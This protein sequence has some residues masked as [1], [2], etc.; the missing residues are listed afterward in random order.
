MPQAP[1]PPQP[2]TVA[3]SSPLA[4]PQ[5]PIASL[6]AALRGH[7][8][9][10]RELGQGAYATV[11]LARDL[12]HERKVAIKVLHA[13][14]NSEMGELR[15][16]REIRM[17]ARLQHPNILPLHDSGHVETLLY[18]VMPYV[19]GETLRDRIDRERRLS[20]DAAC[21]IAREVADALAYAHAQGIIHR[22]IKP[23]NILLSAGHP[24]LADFGIARVIDIAGVRQLTRTGMGSPG[25]PAYM[26][27]EQLLGDNA[28]DA[29]SDTYSLG[30]VLYEMLAGKPPF[31]G[32]EGFVKRF[33]GPPP[34]IAQARPDAA[35]EVS[36]ILKKCLAREPDD[37]FQTAQDF[38]SALATT[39]KAVNG[40]QVRDER[41]EAADRPN[42]NSGTLTYGDSESRPV[43]HSNRIDGIL[44]WVRTH[45]RGV[46]ISLAAVALVAIAVA[47]TQ[48]DSV[49]SVFSP[50]L[51]STQIAVLPIA[52]AA[53]TADRA[54]LTSSLF[55]ALS[56]WRGLRLLGDDDVSRQLQKR[57]VPNSERAAAA[58]ARSLGAG[59]FIWGEAGEGNGAA[60]RLD[61]VESAS[62]QTLRTVSI[63]VAADS[64]AMR[65]VVIQ[66]LRSPTRPGSADGGDGRTTSYPAWTAYGR[67]HEALSRVELAD[68]EHRF[69]E[70]VAADPGFAPA[71]FW[72]AQ[73]LFWRAPGERS[74]W[75][76]HLNQ[77]MSGSAAL[78]VRDRALAVALSNLGDR[79][80][81]EA[82]A[83]YSALARDSL[84]VVAQYGL[85]Q[86]LS[87][88][89]VVVPS[90]SSPSGWSFRSRY[91]DAAHAF[92]SALSANPNAHAILAFDQL[93]ELLPIAPTKTRRGHSID[94]AEFAAYPSLVHDTV[95]F[96]PY[97]V[98]EF[99][100]LPAERT[101]PS[102][103][104]A[105]QADLEFL[106]DFTLD[107]TRRA[108]QSAQAFL[109]L[110][111]VRE[112]RGEISRSRYGE[113][114]A[115]DAARHA[116]S[117]S[118][119]AREQLVART[120]EAW[121]T[122]K[123]GEFTRARVLA[124][125]LLSGPYT[126]ADARDLIGL[127]ALTGKINKT[128]ELARITNDYAA[129]VASVPVPVV[130]AA[131]PFF[132]FAALGICG[133]TV[134][135]LE[136]HLDNQLERFVADVQFKQ[137]QKLVEARPLAML[138]P[139]TGGKA[140]LKIEP[141]MSR[142]LKLEQAFAK[143][144]SRSV[145]SLL[146]SIQRDARTQRPG[147]FSMDF[148]YLVAWVKSALG[149]TV[150]ATRDLDRSLGALP[151]LSAASLRDAAAAAAVGRAMA[152]RAQLANGARDFT[153]QEKWSAAVADL[154]LTADKPLQPAVE[155]M[156]RLRDSARSNSTFHR[157]VR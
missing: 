49:R 11:Y 86:C 70:A 25:T 52:G 74:D 100:S 63:P 105:I 151:S 128:A 104:A 68:A 60:V 132:A 28:V 152:L 66:L 13:D 155:E 64:A 40:N 45:S 42:F 18:Y 79:K 137:T 23:E 41:A 145:Q 125:S 34:D 139:C 95:V 96:V 15:F 112:A 31:A 56:E 16:I 148:V 98:A 46:T 107:W 10:E 32:K 24:M 131:A 133:D 91:S 123:V 134:L 149:D 102:R 21:V 140:S 22:D 1:R 12:K 101:A 146:A 122:F 35:G 115:L 75:R 156:T 103:N 76:D 126:V 136:R 111:D 154:W 14:P 9:F 93:L 144:D 17:L 129:G 143:R 130:D 99:A 135:A 157:E 19:S 33:T 71:H 97:P 38:A 7:Y 124:D 78:S 118:T 8:E 82:C 142:P 94:G 27:P 55:T 110:A 5:D 48:T 53:S 90:R 85:G 77:A 30:C 26:S 73:T 59:R 36:A 88:D 114:S 119:T 6:R 4:P 109:A 127:A 65:N 51:D 81:P 150:G 117:V 116:R 84:D 50:Q 57:G 80:Y 69:R 44:R 3:D 106:L 138:G 20:C 37:R 58:I 54:R 83:Q 43:E 29:R 89:S 39:S 121:L 120:R 153:N 113:M 2:Y 108:P 92:T 147:D 62:R 141:G 47:A 61:L 67:G 72:L 87:S